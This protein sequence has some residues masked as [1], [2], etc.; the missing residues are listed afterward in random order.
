M[1]LNKH[2]HE[3]TLFGCLSLLSAHHPWQLTVGTVIHTQTHTHTHVCRSQCLASDTLSSSKLTLCVL[4]ASSEKHYVRRLRMCRMPCTI[5]SRCHRSDQQKQRSA[6]CA[7]KMVLAA[8]PARRPEE[9][10][11]DRAGRGDVSCAGC[12]PSRRSVASRCCRGRQA[13]EEGIHK[14]Q[15]MAGGGGAL[16]LFSCFACVPSPRVQVVKRTMHRMCVNFFPRTCPLL[17]H[18]DFVSGQDQWGVCAAAREHQRRS[19]GVQAA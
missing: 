19:A 5:A 12:R 2:G 17:V 13:H 9:G 7:H 10:R 11:P 6:E 18:C 8:A 3:S 14:G 1:T 4:S 16:V 15:K